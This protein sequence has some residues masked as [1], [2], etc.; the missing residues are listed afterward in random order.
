MSNMCAWLTP[1]VFLWFPSRTSLF[2]KSIN[3][4]MFFLETGAL[5]VK[6]VGGKDFVIIANFTLIS[7][8]QWLLY[9]CQD[10]LMGLQSKWT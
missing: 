9:L 10:G 6:T 8:V 3:H 4:G 7:T 1:R 2:I 5:F